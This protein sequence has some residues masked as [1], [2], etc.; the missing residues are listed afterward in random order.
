MNPA[1]IGKKP[2]R[3]FTTMNSTNPYSPPICALPSFHKSRALH[4]YRTVGIVASVLFGS[5]YVV[6]AGASIYEY[7][8]SSPP[9]LTTDYVRTAS[10]SVAFAVLSFTATVCFLKRSRI[11]HLLLLMSPM[12]LMVFV[13]PGL[14]TVWNFVERL[15]PF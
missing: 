6:I 9:L 10:A 3:S 4:K 12:L 15:L 14:N 2:F 11:G 5:I 1:V 7:V 8:R 13:F